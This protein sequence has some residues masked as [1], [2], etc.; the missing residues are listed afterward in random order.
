MY[1]SIESDNFTQLALRCLDLVV[2]SRW[3]SVAQ[4]GKHNKIWL[5]FVINIILASL[6]PFQLNL[7]IMAFFN[8]PEWKANWI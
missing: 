8:K 3:W 4:F 5:S 6:T 2:S 1:Q 7:A